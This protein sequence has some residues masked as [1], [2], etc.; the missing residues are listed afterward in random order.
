MLQAM[1]KDKIVLMGTG[2]HDSDRFRSPF[3]DARPVNGKD[4][5]GWTYG[6]EIHA[7]VAATVAQ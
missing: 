6:V 1:F 4:I 2:F 5:Y 3:Y 7:N